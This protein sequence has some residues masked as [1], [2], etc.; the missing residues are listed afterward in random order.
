MV[1]SVQIS[2]HTSCR[3]Q[4]CGGTNRATVPRITDAADL[5]DHCTAQL[6]GKKKQRTY[7]KY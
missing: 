1:E 4:I 2:S 5:T 7:D 3:V 6:T